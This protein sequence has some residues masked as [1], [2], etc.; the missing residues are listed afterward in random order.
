MGHRPTPEE[1]RSKGRTV[2]VSVYLGVLDE[3]RPGRHSVEHER[4]INEVV[5]HAVDLPRTR[6]TC[7]VGDREGER[8]EVRHTST[9][10]RSV[11]VA[12]IVVAVGLNETRYDRALPDPARSAHDERGGVAGVCGGQLR[13]G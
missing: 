3:E 11:V 4:S 9:S 1:H 13:E 8:G 2:H 6:R 10:S 7:R 5:M 12:V